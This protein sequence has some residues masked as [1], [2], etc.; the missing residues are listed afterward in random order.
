MIASLFWQFF[1]ISLLAFG[2]GQ[3]ALP[4]VERVSVAQMGWITPGGFAAAVSFGYVTPGPVLI[5][6]TFVGY[7]AAGLPGAVAATLGAF[8]APTFLAAGAAAGTERFT[9]NRWLRAFGQGASPAVVG[10]LLATAWSLAQQTTL[11]SWP[12]AVLATCVGLLTVWTAINPGWLLLAGALIG[13]LI[14]H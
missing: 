5:T 8:V 7:S 13:W 4:L 14:S 6:A 12:L 1:V 9:R 11:T 10:L 2:G 3:A